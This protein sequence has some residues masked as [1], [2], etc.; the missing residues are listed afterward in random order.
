MNLK[1]MAICI[2]MKSY[3]I[4]KSIANVNKFFKKFTKEYVN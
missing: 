1:N 3:Y 4:S 2:L